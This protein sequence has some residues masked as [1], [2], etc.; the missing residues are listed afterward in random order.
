MECAEDEICEENV[1]VPGP[2]GCKLNIKPRKVHINTMFG[3]VERVFRITGPGCFDPYAEIDFGLFK[4]HSAAVN[5]KGVLKVLTTVPAG[6]LK[7]GVYELRVGDAVG[8]VI[9]R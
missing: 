2:S 8:E 1:C 5:K 9:L 3:P 6:S 4:V 7:K